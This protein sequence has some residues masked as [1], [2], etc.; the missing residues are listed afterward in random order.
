MAVY[1][2][3][4]Q[5]FQ[6]ADCPTSLSPLVGQVRLTPSVFAGLIKFIVLSLNLCKLGVAINLKAAFVHLFGACAEFWASFKYDGW[7]RDTVVEVY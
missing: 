7:S 5:S 3:E 2:C 1:T 6:S 4:V